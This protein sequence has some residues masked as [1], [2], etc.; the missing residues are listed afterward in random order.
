MPPHQ[1]A[2][3]LALAILATAACKKKEE[4]AAAD[5]AAD[6]SAARPVASVPDPTAGPDV[7]KACYELAKARCNKIAFCGNFEAL[8]GSVPVCIG[9]AAQRCTYE[10]APKFG[11]MGVPEIQ[12]C[13]KI[14]EQPPTCSTT[15]N[16]DLSA[17]T[18]VPGTFADGKACASDGQCASLFCARAGA[19]TCGKCAATPKEGDACSDD[20]CGAK[21]LSCVDQKCVQRQAKDGACTKN[22]GCQPD[23]VCTSGKCVAALKT[24]ATCTPT[25]DACDPGELLACDA[26]TKKCRLPF[27]LVKRGEACGE[28]KDKTPARRCKG[29]TTCKDGTCVVHPARHQPCTPAGVTCEPGLSCIEGRCEAQDVSKCPT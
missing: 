5:A 11:G 18:G 12:A 27:A 2:T 7:Q 17:C 9:R 14:Q 29:D 1:R 13:Q 28:A 25:A 21:G 10:L 15:V 6:A 23:L 3:V 4:S 22:E 26:K 24:G 8:E 16:G 20:R 19:A